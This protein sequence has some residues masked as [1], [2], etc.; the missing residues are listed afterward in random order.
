MI[1][2]LIDLLLENEPSPAAIKAKQMGLVDLGWAR[3]GKE[4]NGKM[5]HT[6]DT[7]NGQ[8]V[9]KNTTSQKSS[10][11]SQVPSSTQTSQSIPAGDS[12]PKPFSVRGEIDGGETTADEFRSTY[13]EFTKEEEESIEL[14]AEDAQQSTLSTPVSFTELIEKWKWG[15]EEGI[16][17]SSFSAEERED[18]FRTITEHIQ[19]NNLTVQSPRLFRGVAFSS[20]EEAES[21][22]GQFAV[23]ESVPFPP[24]GWAPDAQVAMDYGPDNIMEGGHKPQTSI[25]FE[26]QAEDTP[27]RGMVTTAFEREMGM[28]LQH[29]VI[30]PGD[31]NYDVKEV[32][33]HTITENGNTRTVYKIVVT[34]SA[35][36]NEEL[37]K[38]QKYYAL[39]AHLGGS[40][41]TANKIRQLHKQRQQSKK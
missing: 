36:T 13:P 33:R 17:A 10:S 41:G 18:M 4:I 6:H 26:L 30:T 40:M 14:D 8:L 12:T 27:I 35:H 22:L 37:S 20:Q 2:R 38:K 11:T 29:E 15:G 5:T 34:Q 23:G 19:E 28:H 9:V 24:C 32:K 7:V 31:T 3:W 25:M 39:V 16:G 21:F 1:I